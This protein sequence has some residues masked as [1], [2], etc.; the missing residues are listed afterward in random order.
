MFCKENKLNNKKSIISVKDITLIS[1]MAVILFLQKQVLSLIP[2]FQLTV[3]LLVLYSKKVGTL[4]TIIIC[5]IYALIDNMVMGTFNVLYTPF[6]F[7]GWI[8]IPIFLNTIFKK[9]ESSIAL[10][11]LGVLFSFIYCWLFLIPNCI[12]LQ[13]DFITYLLSDIVWEILMA[14]SSFLSILLLYKPCYNALSMLLI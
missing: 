7:I 10:A 1:I 2:N 13:M 4:K 3:L 12:V 5:F 8:F 6:L 14:S 9:V 11:F